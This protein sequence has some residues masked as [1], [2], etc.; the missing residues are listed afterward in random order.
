MRQQTKHI[1]ESVVPTGNP[2]EN[3]I[4]SGVKFR[5]ISRGHIDGC[6][7]QSPA[8][9]IGFTITSTTVLRSVSVIR[10]MR[11]IDDSPGPPLRPTNRV[12]L[13]NRLRTLA[14]NAAALVTKLAEGHFSCKPQSTGDTP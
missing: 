4:R 9:P 3:I 11:W 13:Q 1:A 2:C 8:H 7:F 5:G 10:L 14:A 6:L 12:F